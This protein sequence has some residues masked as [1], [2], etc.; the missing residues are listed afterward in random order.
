[1]FSSD[2]KSQSNFYAQCCELLPVIVQLFRV[3]LCIRLKLKKHENLITKNHEGIGQ[4]SAY[5]AT[6]LYLLIMNRERTKF[7]ISTQ[8]LMAQIWNITNRDNSLVGPKR[9]TRRTHGNDDIM[10]SS[11]SRPQ[12]YPPI[13]HSCSTRRI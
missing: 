4:F 1:M 8:S 12:V 5:L 10:T 13:I 3:L 7:T 9:F 11:S 6:C 2:D